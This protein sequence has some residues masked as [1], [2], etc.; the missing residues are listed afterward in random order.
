MTTFAKTPPW[1]AAFLVLMAILPFSSE[2]ADS[3]WR[4]AFYHP[5]AAAKYP[6]SD[7]PWILYT[8]VIE[9]AILPTLDC[10]IDETYFSVGATRAVFVSAAHSHN[11]KAMVSLLQDNSTTAINACTKPDRI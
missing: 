9:A 11:V 4:I 10:G 7:I 3:F 8:H 2:A 6:P 5:R 1:R